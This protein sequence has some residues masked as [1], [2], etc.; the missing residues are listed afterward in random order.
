MKQHMKL[1]Q[2]A[3]IDKFCEARTSTGLASAQSEYRAK[4]VARAVAAFITALDAGI[5]GDKILE[6]VQ[7]AVV[8]RN[9][10][11]ADA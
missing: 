8:E 6:A 11:N 7:E 4:L 5:G 9:R 10:L 3:F 1:T 2:T